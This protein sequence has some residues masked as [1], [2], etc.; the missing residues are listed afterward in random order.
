MSMTYQK[1]IAYH[2]IGEKYGVYVRGFIIPDMYNHHLD[3][4]MALVEEA[5][6]TFPRLAYGDVQCRTVRESRS[7][8]GSPLITFTLPDLKTGQTPALVEGWWVCPTKELSF[9]W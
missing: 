4:Y 8:L 9:G 3:S 7:C 1:Y 6:K 2:D 5:R